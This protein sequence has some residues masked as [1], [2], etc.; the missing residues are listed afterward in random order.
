[1]YC[2]EHGTLDYCPE[3]LEEIKNKKTIEAISLITDALRGSKIDKF[4]RDDDGLSFILNQ[5]EIPERL[6][7]QITKIE[8]ALALLT[9]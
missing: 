4:N 2:D 9:Y 7:K 1:M 5:H 3:C 6:I 8:K